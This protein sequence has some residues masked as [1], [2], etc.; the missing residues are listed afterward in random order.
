MDAHKIAE[1][2]ATVRSAADSALAETL[3][4]SSSET[5]EQ[6]LN[7]RWCEQIFATGLTAEP[8]GWYR[9]PPTGSAVLLAQAPGW[10]RLNFDSLRTPSNLS[11]DCSVP[12][13]GA[14]LYTYASPVST[15]GVACDYGRTIYLGTDEAVV[16]H[17]S[18]CREVTLQIADWVAPGVAFSDLFYEA[19]LLLEREGLTNAT[20]SLADPD[21]LDIGH[22]LPGFRGPVTPNPDAF[23]ASRQFI[24]MSSTEYVRTIDALTIEPR[25]RVANLPMASF[26]I[27]VVIVDGTRQ[28]LAD[29]ENTDSAIRELKERL[30]H[31]TGSGFPS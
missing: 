22:T 5:S 28:I 24:A 6:T 18:H 9:P 4:A 15:G 29:Y 30:A 27:V 2:V 19:S 10:D 21:G 16:M 13:R 23:S 11:S 17:Y 20:F 26:H 3:A 1:Q 7:T 12:L 25:A 31:E 14:A 8:V